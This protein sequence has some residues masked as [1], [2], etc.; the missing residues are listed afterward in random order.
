M[1]QKG[2]AALGVQAGHL[3]WLHGIQTPAAGCQDRRNLLVGLA[4]LHGSERTTNTNVPARQCSKIINRRKRPRY[5][6]VALRR[7]QALHTSMCRRQVRQPQHTCHLPDERSL[8]LDGIDTADLPAGLRNREHYAGQPSSGSDIHDVRRLPRPDG[9]DLVRGVVLYP[10][11]Q[12]RDGCQAIDKV[13]H[14]HGFR[15]ADRRQVIGAV[16]SQHLGQILHEYFDLGSSQ[17]KTYA[18]GIPGQSLGQTQSVDLL[19]HP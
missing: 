17:I 4:S 1:S 5:H 14:A 7:F 18:A 15:I 6:D 9:I 10:L 19:I 16:P 3:Q 11:R 8:F 12:R 2:D 13:M